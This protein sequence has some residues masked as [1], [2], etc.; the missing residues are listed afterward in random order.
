MNKPHCFSIP[1]TPSY[2]G[3]YLGTRLF[4]FMGIKASLDDNA[5]LCRCC[6]GRQ[7]SSAHWLPPSAVPQGLV[8]GVCPSTLCQSVNLQER[9]FC[10]VCRALH[11]AVIHE[12]ES[13]L[14]A[15]LQYVEGTELLDLQNDLGQVGFSLLHGGHVLLPPPAVF[16]TRARLP[17]KDCIL[18]CW[19]YWVN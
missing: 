2:L 18:H 19:V 14:D 12:H 11:L 1:H 7:G 9:L 6:G 10:F 17:V 16:R 13:F 4:F 15:V 5:L 3:R 8:T